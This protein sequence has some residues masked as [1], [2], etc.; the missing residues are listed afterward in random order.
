MP[1]S[2]RHGE[3]HTSGAFEQFPTGL[4]PVDAPTG[5]LVMYSSAPSTVVND[6]GGEHRLFINELVKQLR[7]AELT[8][9]EVFN[10]TRMGVL[11]RIA[12]PASALG[13]VFAG[14]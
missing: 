3:I 14:L 4:A 9:D 10:R 5:S 8:G 12:G 2:T 6:T 11:A 1:F 7:I 13:V